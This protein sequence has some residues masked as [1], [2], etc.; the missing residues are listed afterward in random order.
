MIVIHTLGIELLVYL[1]FILIQPISVFP[2]DKEFKYVMYNDNQIGGNSIITNTVQSNKLLQFDFKL[3]KKIQ[4][5]YV[6]VSIQPKHT[7]YIDVSDYNR[8]SIHTKKTNLQSLSVAIITKNT[9]E[10]YITKSPDVISATSI[11][12]F[13][14]TKIYNLELDQFNV[15]DWWKTLNSINENEIILPD[16]EKVTAIN[17]SNGYTPDIQGEKSLQIDSITF[18]RDNSQLLY[19]LILC[20]ILFVICV[21]IIMYI[22]NRFKTVQSGM[23][24]TYKPIEL[25]TSNESNSQFIQ[26]INSNFHN[27]ELSLDIIVLNSKS[28][29]RTITAYV[30]QTYN[31]NVKTYINRIRIHEAKRLLIESDLLIGEIAYKVGFNNQT[32][33]NRVFKSEMEISPSEF[34]QKYRLK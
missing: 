29:K 21:L 4:S 3:F 8:I 26:Y 5:P 2:N 23:E 22:R 27:P 6:G 12:I 34:I 15:P 11:E 9:N 20:E 28:S 31:C 19:F 13:D 25:D 33:F 18:S 30:Q 1:Y 32:H 16:F 7:Q 17:I 14:N 10:K 24:I